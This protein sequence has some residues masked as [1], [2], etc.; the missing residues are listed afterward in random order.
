M[1]IAHVSTTAGSG[2]QNFSGVW[3]ATQAGDLLVATMQSSEA[4]KAWGANAGWTVESGTKVMWRLATGSES[5]AFSLATNDTG[6]FYD[7]AGRLLQYRGVGA[8]TKT[9]AGYSGFGISPGTLTLSGVSGEHLLL[10]YAWGVLGTTSVG[11]PTGYTSRANSS[12]PRHWRVS[13]SAYASGGAEA[14]FSFG[15]SAYATLLAFKDAGGGINPFLFG[16]EL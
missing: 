4:S 11:T 3:P 15:G 8:I 13:D 9:A 2:I 7:L 6:G 1:T 14:T 16:G 12:S 10:C 5:G